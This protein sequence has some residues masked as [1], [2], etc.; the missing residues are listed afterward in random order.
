MDEWPFKVDKAHESS[1][2]HVLEI[3]DRDAREARF[4]LIAQ[5]GVLFFLQKFYQVMPTD[6]GVNVQKTALVAVFLIGAVGASL[7]YAL[8]HARGR[9]IRFL[10]SGS[11]TAMGVTGFLAQR[12]IVSALIGTGF[13]ISTCA[14]VAGIAMVFLLHV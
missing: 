7:T 6:L 2:S 14:L 13:I 1:W 5:I 3:C 11:T 10:L 4:H 9:A 8:A 12:R